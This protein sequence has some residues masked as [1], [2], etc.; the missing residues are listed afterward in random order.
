MSIAECIVTYII[1]WWM[2]LFMVLPFWVR[3]P[4][5]PGVGHVPSAPDKP[6]LKRKFLITSLLAFLPTL[7]LMGIMDARAEIYHAGSNDCAP[8]ATYKADPGVAAVDQ[9]ATLNPY[10]ADSLKEPTVLLDVPVGDYVDADTYNVDLTQSDLLV[11]TVD[12][13]RDGASLNGH[14][15]GG[16]GVYSSKCAQTR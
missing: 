8:L 10:P 14:P 4:A 2:V 3:P 7:I 12:I 1:S 6:Q 9:D 16:G 15:I 13:R 11:G 5:R